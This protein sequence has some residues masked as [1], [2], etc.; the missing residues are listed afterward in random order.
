MTWKQID[1]LKQWKF[2]IGSHTQT[3]VNCVKDDPEVVDREIIESKR[4]LQ[5]AWFAGLHLRVSVWRARGLQRQM[6]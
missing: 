4:D 1:A 2:G 3:H 6:A 5:R